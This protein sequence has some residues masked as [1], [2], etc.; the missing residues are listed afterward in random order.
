MDTIRLAKKNLPLMA[1]L[2]VLFMLV[3]ALSVFVIRSET[4]RN[5]LLMET[6]ASRTAS[7]LLEVFFEQG[8]TEDPGLAQGIVGF[9]IYGD[10]GDPRLRYGSAPADLGGVPD[11]SQGEE[12]IRN[13]ERGTLIHIRTIAAPAVSLMRLPRLLGR[14]TSRYLYLEIDVRSYLR[15]QAFYNIALAAV[16]LA[17]AALT[18]L[19]GSFALKNAQYREQ[20]AAQE[21]LARL[22]EAARTL[23]HELKNPLNTI[24]LRARLARKTADAEAAADLD[25]VEEEVDRLAALTDR[26]REFLQDARGA[27]ERIDLELFVRDLAS[28]SA[29]S[30]SISTDG[31]P[32]YTVSF[33]PA[34]LRSVVENLI[35]NARESTPS[36]PDA[37]GAPP[38]AASAAAPP[39][40]EVEVR[41]RRDRGEVVLSV[42]DRGTGIPPADA[43]R[44]FEPFYTTKTTGSGIGLSITRRF[45]EAAGGMVQL[46]PREGGGTE[47]RV[48]LRGVEETA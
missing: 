38:P 20:I 27:P 4:E 2:A 40:A 14:L 45:L 6:T 15:R 47:A 1:L 9:G 48:T 29:W 37:L 31:A 46:L 5:R 23:A 35:R 32:G 43:E 28:R 18:L 16:P 7:L 25:V 42:L 39:P 22:G 3:S 21:R 26:I 24:K 11:L 34:R 44:V 10:T 33:D 13:R 30:A 19:A 12:Y 17:I 8:I 41:L 36:G